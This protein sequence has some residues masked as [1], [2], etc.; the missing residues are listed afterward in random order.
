MEPGAGEKPCPPKP[1]GSMV[2]FKYSLRAP[3]EGNVLVEAGA[4]CRATLK[5]GALA[6]E[7]DALL[8]AIGIHGKAR[9]QVSSCSPGCM[10]ASLEG[11]LHC[12]VPRS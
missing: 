7:L 5:T 6:P 2:E 1:V 11:Q 3:S 10:A 4:S 9:C 12:Q 8:D